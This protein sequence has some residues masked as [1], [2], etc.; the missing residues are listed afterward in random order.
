MGRHVGGGGAAA[1]GGGEH[2]GG[3]VEQ[4]QSDIQRIVVRVLGKA[5]DVDEP[6][7]AAGMCARGGVGVDGW[8]C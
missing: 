3:G 2:V 5:V 4:V 1:A 8:R 6:L 7:V